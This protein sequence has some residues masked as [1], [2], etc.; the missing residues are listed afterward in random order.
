MIWKPPRHPKAS[1][2]ATSGVVDTILPAVPMEKMTPVRVANTAGLNHSLSSFRVPIRLQ[3]IPMPSRM[4]PMIP[5]K[6]L[7]ASENTTAPATPISDSPVI[8]R[9]GPTR[10]RKTVMGIWHK[11]KI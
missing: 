2:S 11:A 10:S 5:T 8:K 7:S 6:R 1:T 9:R 4:R 3:A